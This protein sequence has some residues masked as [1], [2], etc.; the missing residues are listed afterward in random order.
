MTVVWNHQWSILQNIIFCHI[1]PTWPHHCITACFNAVLW[2]FTAWLGRQRIHVVFFYTQ[3]SMGE[4]FTSQNERPGPKLR[5]RLLCL[6][7]AWCQSF[8]KVISVNQ[9][10]HNSQLIWHIWKCT[11]SVL[12]WRSSGKFTC[13]WPGVQR[14]CNCIN[15]IWVGAD[16][17]VFMSCEKMLAY[18]KSTHGMEQSLTGT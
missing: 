17:E 15:Q 7:R 16:C 9:P 2:I 18:I 14:D 13:P 3:Q 11:H 4:H 12:R 5:I 8:S 10:N 6:R 1:T